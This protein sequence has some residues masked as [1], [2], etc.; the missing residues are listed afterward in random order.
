MRVAR[1]YDKRGGKLRNE[2]DVSN[3]VS[4]S[5]AVNINTLVTEPG[6]GGTESGA[7]TKG[8]RNSVADNTG[9]NIFR[10]K[11]PEITPF[12]LKSDATG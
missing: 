8:D 12:T 5:K 9:S 3:E 2:E 10:T 7:G 4:D 6:T 1:E 11:T